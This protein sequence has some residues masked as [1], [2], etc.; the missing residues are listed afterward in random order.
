M[1]KK[2]TKH[3]KYVDKTSTDILLEEPS[4]GNPYIAS[5]QFLYGYDIEELNEKKD[6]LDVL[7]L[8]FKGEL[9]SSTE[10]LILEKLMIGFI[11]QG[12]RTSGIR[13]AMTAGVSK[14]RYS[15]LLPIGLSVQSGMVN[16]ADEVMHAYKFISQNVERSHKD[17]ARELESKLDMELEGDFRI[18][19]GI[20][21]VFGGHDLISHNLA[22]TLLELPQCG[23]AINWVNN[24]IMSI[25]NERVGWLP[26]GLTAAT[27]CDLKFGAREAAGFYQIMLA[28][29][30]VCHGLEQTHKP[31]TS[32][33][34]VKDEDYFYE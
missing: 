21:S 26:S 20:G 33:P 13:A 6:Y 2:Q 22:K 8:M 1:S 14:T 5:K 15:N 30:I 23:K 7:F 9:P 10:K 18:A 32:M 12:P 17:V 34:F 29:A 27:L 11:N 31:I 16:G 28:P 4:T 19:S 25:N 3:F 24:L